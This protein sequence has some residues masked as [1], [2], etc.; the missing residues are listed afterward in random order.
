M[1]YY[2]FGSINTS[3][4]TRK[5]DY[6]KNDRNDERNNRV[7]FRRGKEDNKY[8]KI[9]NNIIDNFVSNDRPEYDKELGDLNKVINNLKSK[10]EENDKIKKKL[11]EDYTKK[12]SDLQRKLSDKEFKKKKPKLRN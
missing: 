1:E 3:I 9:N 7:L 6:Y 5:D 11:E 8:V 12:I 4:Y 2:N 10:L